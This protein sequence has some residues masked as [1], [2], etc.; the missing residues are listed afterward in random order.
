M[1]I[2][3]GPIQ[4]VIVHSMRFHINMFTMANVAERRTCCLRTG[5]GFELREDWLLECRVFVGEGEQ[6]Y[7]CRCAPPSAPLF[8]LFSSKGLT[9][10]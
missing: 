10:I 8:V 2:G 6:H 4:F 5:T 9:E 1:Q 7:R 3:S